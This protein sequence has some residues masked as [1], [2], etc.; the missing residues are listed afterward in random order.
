MAESRFLADLHAQFGTPREHVVELVRRVTGSEVAAVQRI[1]RGYD[2]EVHRVDL[3]SGARV[4]VRIR[5]DEGGYDD[6]AWA[7]SQARDHGVPVPEVIGIDEVAA[8][9]GV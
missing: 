5:R 2:N 4:F 3:E 9:Q 7:M 6:E 1:T 8:D